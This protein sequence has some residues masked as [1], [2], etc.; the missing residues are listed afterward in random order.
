[1]L[2]VAVLVLGTHLIPLPENGVTFFYYAVI[3][4]GGLLA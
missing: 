4:A 1:M 3:I 2:L